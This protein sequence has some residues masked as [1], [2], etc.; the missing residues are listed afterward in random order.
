M[1]DYAA[2]RVLQA[3]IQ[4][5]SFDRA[6]AALNVTPS[7]VSQRIKQLEERLGAAL[8]VRANPCTATE[9]GERLCRH[10]EHVGMLEQ[11][12]LKGLPSLADPD[13]RQ[14]RVTLRIATNADSL[15]TWF[16]QAM[17]EFS[18]SSRYLLDIAVDDQDHTADWLQQG[19]VI[20]AVTGTDK[21][22]SGCR[23]YF[24]GALRYHATASPDFVERH[25]AQGI[26][27]ASMAQAPSMTFN[28]KDRLQAD[29][30]RSV[31]GRDVNL[32]THWLPSTQSF[33][34]A[35]LMGLGWGMNPRPLVQEH[36]ATG[37]LVELVPG[38]TLDIKL[39]WHINRLAAD[40][41]TPLTQKVIEVSAKKLSQSR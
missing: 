5:G 25:F 8:V 17:S 29:W 4:T 10:M 28:Q 7:A 11:D 22:I 32:P 1:I 39:Y 12:L 35:S 37:R 34:D 9:K 31:L 36:L 40:Q 6:A 13:G 33:V 21:P 14:Q 26:T 24:L 3:V 38:Q 16:L 30:V 15:A 27:P 20:A 41:L 23:R 19:K 18:Q 2:L